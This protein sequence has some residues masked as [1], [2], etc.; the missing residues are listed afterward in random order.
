ML[1]VLR[2]VF[3]FIN[4]VSPGT[5]IFKESRYCIRMYCVELLTVLSANVSQP[6]G[7]LK[8]YRSS[9]SQ[10]AKKTFKNSLMR[11]V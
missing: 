3:I 9:K 1:F 11:I 7:C 8:L 2:T 4:L 10:R 5:A 6:C